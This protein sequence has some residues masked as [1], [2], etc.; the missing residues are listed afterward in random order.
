MTT[1]STGPPT[2]SKALVHGARGVRGVLGVEEHV[3]I[4]VAPYSWASSAASS[5]SA[6]L[7]P[8]RTTVWARA[9]QSFF[10]IARAMS[11]LP[12]KTTTLWG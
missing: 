2:F 8:A 6:R 3:S 7:R 1:R 12:P 11:E 5:R 4:V 10:V 9:A